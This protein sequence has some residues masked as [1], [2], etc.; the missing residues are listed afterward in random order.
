MRK[1]PRAAMVR[2]STTLAGLALAAGTAL[3][4]A[5]PAASAA[6]AGPSVAAAPMSI[7]SGF[8]EGFLV[9][10][11]SGKCLVPA[12]FNQL[13]DGDLVEQEPCD[14]TTSQAWEFVP[15]GTQTFISHS[16]PR[17]DITYP[18]YHIVN[19]GTGLCLDDRDGVSSDGAAVQEWTCN[20]TSTTMMWA[21]LLSGAPDGSDVIFNARA[22]RNRGTFMLLGIAS[23]ST[24][25]NAPAELFNGPRVSPT[26]EDWTFNQIA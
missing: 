7:P 23:G 5:M 10:A 19:A 22:S 26:S 12:R 11:N 9:N 20:S 21:H 1:M 2:A 6:T 15:V 24:E 13:S 4:G 16:F 8:A 17:D 14:G 25:D 3:G 18:A